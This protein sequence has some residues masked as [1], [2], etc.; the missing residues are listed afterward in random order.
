MV[1]LQLDD[2]MV[3]R[4]LQ[5]D[6]AEA[7][8]DTVTQNYEHLKP[9]THW[10]TPDYSL[11]SATEFIE[12]SDRDRE[13]RRTLELGIFDQNQFVGSIGFVNFD[14]AAKKTEIGYWISKAYEGKGIV[15]AACKRLI[16]FAFDELDLKRIEIRSSTENRR[17]VAIPERLGFIKEGVLRQATLC[18][19]KLHDLAIYGL[20]R[21][22]WTSEDGS[23]EL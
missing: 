12:R 16:R 9:F 18:D 15:C 13:E 4:D 21:A 20:L 8:L 6:D 11:R 7:I 14:W 2:R 10:I 1:N 22:E 23:A 19:G 3:L 5:P 17:S